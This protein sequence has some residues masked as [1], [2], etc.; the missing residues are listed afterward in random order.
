MHK[1][2]ADGLQLAQ[3][4]TAVVQ[5]HAARNIADYKMIHHAATN[6]L[7]GTFHRPCGVDTVIYLIAI[8]LTVPV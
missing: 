6:M 4:P 3:P 7:A 5:G 8:L 2:I 1:A